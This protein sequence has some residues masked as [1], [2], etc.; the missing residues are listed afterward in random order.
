[1]LWRL[2]PK[3]SR[4]L[5]GLISYKVFFHL[6]VNLLVSFNVYCIICSIMFA[7]VWKVLTIEILLSF[8][9]QAAVIAV[10][11]QWISNFIVSATFYSLE[12][13]CITFTY[14]LYGVMSICSMIFIWKM[15]PETKDKTLEEMNKLW[16]H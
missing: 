7:F 15:V 5:L 10:A 11:A 2:S 9:Q 3:S 13:F 6:D 16:K 12:V 4:I 14:L 8:F 1:M